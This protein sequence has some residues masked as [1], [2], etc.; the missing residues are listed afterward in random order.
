MLDI[1]RHRPFAQKHCRQERGSKHDKVRLPILVAPV[2]VERC[3]LP[4]F[5]RGNKTER[6]ID[7]D[8]HSRRTV[9]VCT[10]ERGAYGISP[11]TSPAQDKGLYTFEIEL[12]EGRSHELGHPCRHRRGSGACWIQRRVVG[13]YR[14]ERRW[15]TMG[16]ADASIPGLHPP[17][18]HLR[19]SWTCWMQW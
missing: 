8:D 2:L 11:T 13:L 17:H 12:S 7:S 14:H 18:R 9:L 19:G 6:E 3:I 10:H 16:Y 4:I 15:G 5:C 1:E